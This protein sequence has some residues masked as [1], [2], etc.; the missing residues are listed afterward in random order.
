MRGQVLSS[1]GTSPEFQDLLWH[2]S[3]QTATPKGGNSQF[4]AV[5]DP[6]FCLCL[7]LVA[8]ENSDGA[9]KTSICS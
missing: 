8:G 1:F 5:R 4:E 2:T 7:E 9:A 6:N 3:L